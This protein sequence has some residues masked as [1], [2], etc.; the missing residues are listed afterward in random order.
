MMPTWKQQNS[1]YSK[2]WKLLLMPMGVLGHHDRISADMRT[3]EYY[4]QLCISAELVIQP[5]INES[6]NMI[7]DLR[8]IN[9]YKGRYSHYLTITKFWYT[10]YVIS[11]LL[12]PIYRCGQLVIGLTL[13]VT[14]FAWQPYC[15]AYSTRTPLWPIFTTIREHPL[16][17]S[18]ELRII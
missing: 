10:N 5:S 13:V 14:I 3:A 18:V 16:M 15:N 1:L 8:L 9:N 6:I 7:F 12:I 4:Y 11:I 17:P 2:E